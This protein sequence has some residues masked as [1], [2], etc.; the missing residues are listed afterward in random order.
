MKYLLPHEKYF[1]DTTP[2]FSFQRVRV[3]TDR[4]FVKNINFFQKNL[5]I[6]NSIG[7]ECWGLSMGDFQ[8][9]WSFKGF[10]KNYLLQRLSKNSQ[11]NPFV[12]FFLNFLSHPL[13]IQFVSSHL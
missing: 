5:K 7:S 11:F 9:Y 4:I 13:I 10:Q 6:W 12:T 1:L 8:F 2:S 3:R